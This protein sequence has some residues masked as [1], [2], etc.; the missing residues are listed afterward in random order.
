[1]V[2]F[3]YHIVGRRVN[4]M[5]NNELPSTRTILKRGGIAL[6]I[7]ICV[8]VIIW[9]FQNKTPQVITFLGI[10]IGCTL[11]ALFIRLCIDVHKIAKHFED[12]EIK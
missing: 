4:L 2:L 11:T 12:K 5:E 8:V 10:A 7:L 9:G 6:V 3:V 1:M